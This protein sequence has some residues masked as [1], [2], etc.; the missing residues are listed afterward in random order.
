[1]SGVGLG[2]SFCLD[3]KM[4][5]DAADL[6]NYSRNGGKQAYLHKK[7]WKSKTH[8][9]RTDGKVINFIEMSAYFSVVVVFSVF[10]FLTF[11]L[12]TLHF[13]SFQIT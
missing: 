1:V 6:S 11:L 9:N 8:D 7:I 12:F 3:F 2:M 13:I 10:F 4:A 5:G